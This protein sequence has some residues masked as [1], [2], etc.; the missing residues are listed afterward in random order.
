MSSFAQAIERSV[1]HPTL[2]QV[3]RDLE[4]DFDRAE[5]HLIHDRRPHLE[6]KWDLHGRLRHGLAL[7]ME[8]GK[9]WAHQFIPPGIKVAIRLDWDVDR[10]IDEITKHLK[11]TPNQDIRN[12]IHDTIRQGGGATQAIHELSQK[13]QVDRARDI[14]RTVYMN[15]YT[16]SALR[17][18]KKHGYSLAKRIEIDDSKVCPLCKVLNNGTYEIDYLLTSSMPL[19]RGSHP[20]CRGTFVPVINS[21][22]ALPQRA[23][24]M[25]HV[26]DIVANGNGM[27]N[28][29]VE[30]AVH[31]RR[32]ASRNRLP[33][34]VLF[35]PRTHT[36]SRMVGD[37]LWIHPAALHDQDPR[38]LIVEHWATE[39]WPR[40]EDKFRNEFVSLLVWTG[41][42]R[43][44]KTFR[45]T[46]ELWRQEFVAYKLGLSESPWHHIWFRDVVKE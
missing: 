45:T 40:Y 6:Q 9:S 17:E 44:S 24:K 22:V 41:L 34:N 21:M 13:Y 43:P 36:N 26:T 31:L 7:V 12:A 3:V 38:E 29:P 10:D 46:E 5:T 39:V 37:T 11:D 28:V 15:I 18:M 14:A 27:R 23:G 16:K 32:F 33:F 35:D 30:Y 8:A 4:G 19:T 20:R 2:K 25:D 1:H 42:A